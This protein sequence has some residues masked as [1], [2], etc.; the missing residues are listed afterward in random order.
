MR[1]KR[2]AVFALIFLSSCNGNIATIN[3]KRATATATAVSKLAPTATSRPW[4]TPTITPSPCPTFMPT[5]IISIDDL[6]S[7]N[8]AMLPDFINDLTSIESPT[9]YAIN[10]RVEFDALA[11]SALLE[12]IE[13]IRYT[14]LSASAL[15]DLVLML[16]PNDPQ[17]MAQMKAG[18]ALVDG[19]IIYPEEELDGLALRLKLSRPLVPG[20]TIDISIPFRVEAFGPIGEQ[21]PRRFGITEGVLIAP[22][23][24]PLVPRLVDGEWQ[25]Q[26]APE[27]GDA[28]N[29]DIAY[30]QV[31]I[32]FSEE[33]LLAASGLEV[34]RQ[35][36]QDGTETATFVTGPMRDFAF[37]L[38]PFEVFTQEA[39]DVLL[40]AWVLPEHI[41]S[42][43]RLLNAAS[44]QMN[45][46]SDLVGPYPYPELDLVDA[47]GA[48]G[49]IEY[50][51]LVFIGTLGGL[52]VI[53]PT[54][55]EVAHQWFYGLIGSD[56]LSNP[57]MDEAA[58]VYSEI[59]YYEN[60]N[61]QGKAT[62][63]LSNLRSWVMDLPDP[64]MPI[65]RSVSE[66]D[67]ANDYVM[68]VYFKGALFF[69]ALRLELGDET[70]FKFLNMYY[71]HYRYGFATAAD[72]Q[73][74]A[75]N[76][77]DCDLDPLFDLWV[78]KGG[79][80]YGG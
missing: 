62:G 67:S 20:A 31:K 9:C 70:F 53:E 73:A 5:P 51:G 28:T 55:H 21:S 66:Y 2:L 76:V 26:V 44:N 74:I 54:V 1:T 24:Y 16:W 79:E 52:N 29:S 45:I 43:A 60:I 46:M 75:E 78:N 14:N 69:D 27:G 56:Q 47:P 77:C 10:V 61:G 58:A 68:L 36:N 38:G 19:E 71:D 48:F 35:S 32:R 65:G 40:R 22:T 49:G 17:Y 3:I 13:R 25:I 23:F 33:Y 39:G 7:Q 12:G 80:F 42:S 4:A 64:S 72:F 34:D 57:W 6:S 15:T 18:P 30:Y 59:L 63:M 37:A 8:H 50:P 11:Q 41:D